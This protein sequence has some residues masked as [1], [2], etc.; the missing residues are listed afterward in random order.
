MK[1]KVVFLKAPAHLNL[2]YHKGQLED[3]ET[4]LADELI[5]T[6]YAEA[7]DLDEEEKPAVEHS[8]PEGI[9]HLELLL[10]NGITD[11]NKL[12]EVDDLTDLKGIGDAKAEDIKNFWK[13]KEQA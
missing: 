9:P 3:V 1:T 13:E 11:L 12:A 4:K 5:E 10:D 2:A 8:L 6:G 7:F